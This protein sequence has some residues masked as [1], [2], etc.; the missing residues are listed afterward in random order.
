MK[1]FPLALNAHRRV[2][3]AMAD[4]TTIVGV[5]DEMTSP[6]GSVRADDDGDPEVFSTIAPVAAL[7]LVRATCASFMRRRRTDRSGVIRLYRYAF[8]HEM[9][10]RGLCLTLSLRALGFMVEIPVGEVGP[11]WALADGLR[12]LVPLG[13]RIFHVALVGAPM[14]LRAGPY[15]V[16]LRDHFMPM[17]LLKHTSVVFPSGALLYRVVSGSATELIDDAI[18]LAMIAA[19]GRRRLRERLGRDEGLILYLE[20]CGFPFT[21]QLRSRVFERLLRAEA[22]VVARDRELRSLL[23]D[24]LGGAP[25]PTR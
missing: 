9:N 7:D 22:P 10:A 5:T 1:H 12:M 15:V 16:W 3:V 4:P 8:V 11:L 19:D 20:L 2:L 23:L 24:A 14:T 13:A 18:G 21:A 25:A 17:R 6:Q